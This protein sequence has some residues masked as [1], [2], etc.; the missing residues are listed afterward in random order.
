MDGCHILKEHGYKAFVII[1]IKS[2][3]YEF[4]NIIKRIIY[5]YNN[6]H[7]LTVDIKLN[8]ATDLNY[9][10]LSINVLNQISDY[11]F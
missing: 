11:I 6:K 4:E 10:R 3:I 1:K 8:R 9:P 7:S 2:S 5:K